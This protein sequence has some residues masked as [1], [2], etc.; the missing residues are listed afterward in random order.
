VRKN[1]KSARVPEHVIVL[2]TEP[3]ERKLFREVQGVFLNH[4]KKIAVKD[5]FE[6]IQKFLVNLSKKL[7][8]I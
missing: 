5:F 8:H 6:K 7:P 3:L 1:V 4:L 2:V